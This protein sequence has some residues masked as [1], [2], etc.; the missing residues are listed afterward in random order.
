MNY[1]RETETVTEGKSAVNFKEMQAEELLKFLKS[2]PDIGL[3][4][5]EAENRLKQYGCNEVPEVK[6][7]PVVQFLKKF[8]GLTAW[9]LELIII[10]S[11]ILGKYPDFY[12]VTGLLVLNSIIGFAQEQKASGAVDALKKRLQVNARV[13][14]DRVWKTIPARDLVPGDIVRLRSGDFVPADVKIITGELSVDQSALTGESMEVDKKPEDILY[15]GSIVRRGE[16]NG[17]VVLTG[18]KTYFGRTAQL[19]QLAR[20]ELHIEKVISKVVKW[21]LVIVVVSLS[22]AIGFSILRGMYLLEILPLMLVLLLSAIPVALPVMFT[23]SMAVGSMELARKGVL[24]TRLSASEDAA[25]MD[26]V[27]VDKTG[28]I[29]MNR[30]SLMNVIPW[31]G[32]NKQDVVLYGALASQAANQDPIDLAFIEAAQQENIAIDSFVQESFLPFDPRTR[33]TEAMVRENGRKFR[34]MKGAVTII[35]Q[36]CELDETAMSELKGKMAAFAERGRRTLAVAKSEGRNRPQLVG[37]AALCDPPRSDS[38]RLIEELRGMGVPVKMLTGD[39]LQI[40]REV[41]KE[42]G[43]GEN[44]KE[45]SELR[46]LIK[47]NPMEAAELAEESDGFAEIY[48][49]DKYMVVKSLQAKGHIAGMTGDGV[50]DA[51]ALKQAEVGIAVS[52][53]TDVAKGA[54]S[55]VLTDEGLSDIVGLIKVGRMIYERIITWIL[56]KISRTILKSSLVVLPFLITGKYVISAFAMILVVFMTDFVKISLSTDN[57]TWSKKPC[58]WNIVRPVKVAVVLGLLMVLEASGLLYIGMRYFGLM[59]DDLVLN[60]FTFETLF[61]FAMFSIFV[62]RERRHFWNSMP[63]RTLAVAIIADIAV[64]MLISTIGIPGL[65]AIALPVTLFVM[66]Y[67]FLFSLVIND[68]IKFAL[69]KETGIVW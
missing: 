34:V 43:L 69:I 42:V 45:A 56:N 58:S 15:S 7:H 18:T 14:R 48:P 35:T 37:L 67:S 8:W 19:V 29:T 2:D 6:T 30:L 31:S 21:L 12:I 20:P 38:A 54:A 33:R 36:F 9:M 16:V 41:A 61:Y 5:V 46:R 63:S 64:A 68:A 3:E 60:T 49:E 66:A 59:Y 39:A 51:P 32:F 4:S 26:I 13:R 55:V 17:L 57:V 40:A 50:N 52:N 10:L 28:T 53:A 27:C 24:V 23:V 22:L 62:V 1:L 65:K 44:V 11:W 25:L 47:E